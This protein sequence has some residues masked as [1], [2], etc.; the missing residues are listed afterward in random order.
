MKKRFTDCDKWDDAW[1]R[2]LE[3][4]FKVVWEYLR[5]KCDSAGYWKV[6]VEDLEFR[7]GFK[8]NQVEVFAAINKGKQRI[9]DHGDHWQIIG[10]VEFQYGT[11]SPNCKAHT[12]IIAL[13]DKYDLKGYAKGL[14]THKDKDKDKETDKEKDKDK[15]DFDQLATFEEFWK[16]YPTKVERSKALRIYCVLAVRKGTHERIMKA[17]SCYRAHLE[18]NADWK[19]AKAAFNW[20]ESWVDWENYFEPVKESPE[21]QASMK[22]LGVKA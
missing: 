14:Q 13:I 11:L 22:K 20:L 18:A 10:F 3:P 4:Q 21:F 8:T 9:E 5:D 6:D 17:L 19:Q 16:A 7:C 12:H 1:F 15:E 2:K